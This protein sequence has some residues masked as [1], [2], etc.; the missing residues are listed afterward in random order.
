MDFF[1][2]LTFSIY[3]S[4]PQSDN[5]VRN[6]PRYYGIQFNYSGI[7]KLRIDHGKQFEVEGAYV[8][9]TYP[10]HFFEYGPADKS[11]RHHN[12]ICTCG[13]RIQKYI[14]GGLWNPDISAPLIQIRH[15]EKFLSNMQE[16]MTL[17]QRPGPVSPRAVMMFEDLLLQIIETQEEETRHIPYQ[18]EELKELIRQIYAAPEADWDFVAEAERFHVSPTHFRRIFK[19]ITDLPPQQFLLQIRLSKAAELLKSTSAPVKEI[20]S[21][22]GW[23]NVFYF[24]RLFRQK[25][26]IP[27]QRYRKEF[28]S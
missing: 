4:E 25:Y 8:F 5:F 24:S 22:A 3:G 7:L 28:Q 27:P 20:A 10:G 26:H 12:Y 1:D 14:K 19:E 21:L 16:I 15:P 23:E 11:T 6:E 17:I 18:A 13:S 9:L 2:G